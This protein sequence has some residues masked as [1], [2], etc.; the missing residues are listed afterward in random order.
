MVIKKYKPEHYGD[1]VRLLI[2]QSA[3]IPPTE[4]TPKYGFMAFDDDKAIASCFLRRVEG[5]YGQ[6][7]GLVVDKTIAK[8]LK[9]QAIDT[10]I[11]KCRDKAKSLRMKG[12]LAFCQS[13]RTIVTALSHGFVQ[14]PHTML[15]L[16]VK[17]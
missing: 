8:C 1:L 11:K 17:G 9:R 16:N 12:V 13:D 3:H 2:T 10:V 4:E 6:I 7:D 5:G 14:L 15:G